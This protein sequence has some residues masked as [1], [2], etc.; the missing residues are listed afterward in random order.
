MAPE[1]GV[2]LPTMWRTGTTTTPIPDAARHAE[3]LGFGSLWA[4]DQLIA[5]TGVPFVDSTV[6][7]SAAAAVTERVALGWGVMIVPLRHPAWIAR[8]VAS[9]QELSG[10]RAILGV[11]VGGDRHERSWAA[12]GVDRRRRGRLTDE[13][14]T[15]LPQLIAGEQVGLHGEAV[16]L[17]PGATVPPIVVGGTAPAPLRRSVEHGD[18]WFGVPA[19]LELQRD[20]L[21]QINELADLAGRPAP[22]ITLSTMIALDDDPDAPSHDGL[23]AQLTDPDGLFGMPADAVAGAVVTGSVERLAD[24]LGELGELGADRIVVTVAA[25]DWRRQVDLLA[26]ASGLS[27][28]VS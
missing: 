7:L 5:G 11:G 20:L 24:H 23:R 1:I 26:D 10:G 25:G 17:L 13:A 2:F 19:P 15:V 4:V 27:S 12:A 14:L 22:S 21:R 16:Q 3:A 6:A 28:E 9:L 8:E 18:G